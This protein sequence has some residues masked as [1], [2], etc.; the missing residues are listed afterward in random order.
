MLFLLF[1]FSLQVLEGDGVNRTERSMVLEGREKENIHKKKKHNK[2]RNGLLHFLHS[3]HHQK[4]NFKFMDATTLDGLDAVKKS[5]LQAPPSEVFAWYPFW[6]KDAYKYL[7]YNV[8]KTIA[9]FSY[10]VDPKTGDPTALHDW[11]TTPLLDSAR[12]HNTNVLLTVANFGGAANRQFLK[13]NTAMATCIGQVVSWVNKRGAQGVCLDFEAID[14]AQKEAFTNFVQ[15]LRTALDASKKGALLYVAVPAVDYDK[16]FDFQA[17]DTTVD[18]M[19]IMGYNYYGASSAVAGPV[20]P[21]QSGEVWDKENLTTSVEYYLNQQVPANKLILALPFYGNMWNTNSSE[22]GSK[23]TFVGTRT[24]DYAKEAEIDKKFIAHFD[25]NSKGTYATYPHEKK[26]RQFWYD[27]ARAFALK[28]DL[29]NKKKIRGL[30]IWALGYGTSNTEIWSA[31]ASGLNTGVTIP[32]VPNKKNNQA[33]G[34]PPIAGN[35]PTTGIGGDKINS[36]STTDQN[37]KP[38]NGTTNPEGVPSEGATAV[39]DST[40]LLGEIKE[41]LKVVDASLKPITDY[42]TVA[43]YIIGM[44]VVYGG[45]AF[46]CALFYAD[47][48][49]LLLGTKAKAIYI[50]ILMLVLLVMFFELLGLVQDKTVALI[51]GFVLGALALFFLVKSFNK[52]KRDLP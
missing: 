47:T 39:T 38:K 41:E 25:T 42:Q 19:V 8:L 10:E 1:Y 13:N 17:L 28:I 5:T 51:V 40:T 32:G 15:A 44:G 22:L 18:A 36:G 37:T 46:I 4:G 34:S 2:K 52:F 14:G 33:G 31:I 9:Y 27:D 45:I 24:Y 49:A 23:G 26:F 7:H 16:S 21:L 11:A 6:E 43:L 30:G 35:N 29:I 20:D 50:L 48:R 12:K 3:K